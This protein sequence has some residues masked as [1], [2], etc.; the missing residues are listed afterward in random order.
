MFTLHL[1]SQFEEFLSKHKVSLFLA[2]WQVRHLYAAKYWFY[3]DVGLI[4]T[5]FV[6]AVFV[7]L[8]NIKLGP[9]VLIDIS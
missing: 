7:V 1:K 5:S 9:Y 8:F 2:F 4:T 6:F 3:S